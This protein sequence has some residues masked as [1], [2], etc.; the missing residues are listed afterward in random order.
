MDDMKQ[1]FLYFKEHPA[2]V[3]ATGIAA[4]FGACMGAVAYFQSWLG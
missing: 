2:A 4:F 3:A 1:F